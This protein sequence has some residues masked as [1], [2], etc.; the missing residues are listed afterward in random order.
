MPK[1][2]IT[3]YSTTAANNTDIGG[4]DSQGSAAASNIDD[5]IRELASHL[6][7]T[8]A[9]TSP[10]A[11]TMTIADAVDLTKKLR[12]DCGNITTAT[13]RVL[14]MPD[15]DVT[16]VSGT[17]VTE[18]GSQTLTNKTLTSPVLTTPQIND[19]SADHQYIFAVSELAADRTVTLPLLAASD[20]FV[21]LAHNT[22]VEAT[23]TTGTGTTES[24]VTP[25]KI[26]AAAIVAGG[27][28]PDAVLEDQKA[29]TTDG[30]T[31]TSGSWE[32]RTLNT[33]VRDNGG[34][35]SIAA[36]QFTPTVAGWVEWE[37]PAMRVGAHQS[38]LYNVTGAAAVA[39]GSNASTGGAVDNSD[40][41]CGGA[42]VAAGTAYRIEHR[43]TSTKANDG[44]G[45]A[46]SFGGTEVYTRV[47]FWRTA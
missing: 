39:Y 15:A 30:G 25:A 46:N 20:S 16:L 33:E 34:I 32:T 37:A 47:K 7:E 19:T 40:S 2:A 9:G 27:G 26:K 24:L 4:V 31:A 45:Q 35:I 44:Y 28:A 14:T 23:W 13:T 17:V 5:L 41:S 21:F 6:A 36:N 22:Q 42:P 1:N 18:T 43:V 12:I 29:T 11:D 3:D 10:W 8:N 38:R